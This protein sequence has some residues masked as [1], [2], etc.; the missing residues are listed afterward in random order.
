MPERMVTKV[1]FFFHFSAE[2]NSEWF[3]L[4]EE[5][6]LSVAA[7]LTATFLNLAADLLFVALSLLCRC[8]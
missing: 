8:F 6:I 5:S 7:S 4:K 2:L 1:S 3:K